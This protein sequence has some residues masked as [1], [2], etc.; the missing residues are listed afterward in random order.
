MQVLRK[1]QL[2][3]IDKQQ[4]AAAWMNDRPSVTAR[5][6]TSMMAERV[7]REI[8]R[9]VQEVGEVPAEIHMSYWS[10]FNLP[11]DQWFTFP[12]PCE[13]R[14]AMIP[15]VADAR[16]TPGRVHCVGCAETVRREAVRA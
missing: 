11:G 15:V 4:R 7:R 16:V 6:D 3:S 12:F 10:V 8:S 1:T 9:F 13:G 14:V 2:F 5:V